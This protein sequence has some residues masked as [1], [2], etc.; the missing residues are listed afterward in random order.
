MRILIF[1]DYLDNLGGGERLVLTLAREIGADIATM[2]LNRG[3]C[4]KMGCPETK[5]INLGQTLKISPLKQI[6]ATLTYLLCDFRNQYD[7]FILSGNW[8]Q[9]ASINHHKNLWY[10]H[11]PTRV[12]YDLHQSHLKKMNPLLKPFFHL[13][14]CLH[15]AFDGWS[16]K[17][18]DE[19]VTNS[20][21]TQKRIKKYYDRESEV[22]YTAIDTD[23]YYNKK[24]GD[25][26][27]SVNRIYP[28]KRLEIQFKAFEKLP[29]L[30]LLVVGDTLRGDHSTQ[31]KKNLLEHKPENV[32]LLGQL[33]D[34]KLRELYSTC[35]GLICTAQDEDLGVTPIEAQASGKP[36][37]A[38]DEG[39]YRETILDGSTGRLV[40]PQT[41]S[42]V[43][44]V[45]E[46]DK[47]PQVY[48]QACENQAKKFDTKI[49]IEKIRQKLKP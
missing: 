3:V 19:I 14:T 1:H 10:C 21:N 4:E 22:V 31:Y 15:R 41:D 2:D 17:H 11:T 28:E 9:Y 38:V 36:V 42:I 12:F 16:V 29:H 24:P 27:L 46:V 48:R 34:E 43:K 30:R 13:W 25:F 47:D 49:F 8:A 20:R 37:V 32:E 33:S 7:F 45:E 40:Q 39:G 18:I 5:I 26:W 23:R 44:A 6:Q 35:R